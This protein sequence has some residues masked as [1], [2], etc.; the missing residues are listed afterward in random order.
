[1]KIPDPVRELIAAGPYAHVVTLHPDGRPHVT[2]AWA[3]FDDDDIVFSTFYDQHKM[4]D[5]R[6]DPRVSIS[7]HAKEHHGEGMW[8]YVVI[9]GRATVTEGGALAVMD[10]LSP[11]Y[12]GQD[13][14]PE[15][16]HPPGATFRVSVER[17][18]GVGPWREDG[19]D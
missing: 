2:L 7:F 9:E 12:L 8:P 19:A 14:Y 11:A 15:R 18:Y 3:G 13:R 6:R 4:A 17:V 1:M 5:L 10:K 16:D